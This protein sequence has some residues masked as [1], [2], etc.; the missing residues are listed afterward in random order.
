MHCVTTRFRV[1]TPWQ[2]FGLYRAYRR[3]RGDL[4]AAPGLVRYAFL[5]ESPTVCCTLS[6]WASHA[7]MEQ[8]SSTSNHPV[9]Y[10]KQVCLEIWSTYWDLD[11][12]SKYASAWDGPTPWPE[13]VPHP[14]QPWR[15]VEPAV[16]LEAT[17]Q[18]EQV[19]NVE[20][21]RDEDAPLVATLARASNRSWDWHGARQPGTHEGTGEAE[22]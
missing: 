17:R 5:I 20:E 19:E 3:M 13:L 14:E 9:R 4:R 8:F 1:R 21:H 12:L 6:V 22:R 15:L 18:I 10:A 7:A 2:L 11:A 16:A